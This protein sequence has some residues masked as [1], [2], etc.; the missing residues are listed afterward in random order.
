VW[1]GGFDERL[2]EPSAGIG[3]LGWC[4]ALSIGAP[5]DLDDKNLS[6]MN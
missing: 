5:P 3:K 2:G 4:G 1:E 6:N